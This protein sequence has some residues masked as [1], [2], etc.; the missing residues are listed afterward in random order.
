[1]S[2]VTHPHPTALRT[3]PSRL[4]MLILSLIVASAAVAGALLLSSGS[5][6]RSSATSTAPAIQVG[7]PNEAARGQASATSAGAFR[8]AE[9]GG[10]NEAAR[11]QASAAATRP[12]VTPGGATCLR[13]STYCFPAGSH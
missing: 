13:R 12:Q 4:S 2:S 8:P 9:T 5:S 10:P 7:G 6:D 11:G 1:M 3:R